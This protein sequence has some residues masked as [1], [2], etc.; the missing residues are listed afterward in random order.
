MGPSRGRT[1]GSS[2]AV[3]V[4]LLGC[5]TVGSQV[6]RAILERSSATDLAV[7]VGAP[8]ELCG[9]AVARRDAVRH[10]VDDSLFTFDAAALIEGTRPDVVIELIGGTQAVPLLH[11]A[12]E[13]GC[14]V[15]TANKSVLAMHLRALT[16]L[17]AGRGVDLLYEAAVAGAIP[18]VRVLRSSLAG[19][20]LTRIL[21]IVNGT[22]NFVLT[23]MSR[24]HRSY[25]DVL[26]QATAL[27]YAE[28]DASADVDGHDAA[29]KAAILATLA[30]G[31]EVTDADV[32]REGISKI[33]PADLDAARRMGYVVRLLAV[34]E[35]VDHE[36]LTVRV[37]PTMLPTGHPLASVEGATNAIFVEGA[38]HGP[39]MLEGRGA[40]G[41]E[42]ASAVLGDLVAVARNRRGG[43]TEQPPSFAQRAILRPAGDVASAFYLAIEVADRPGVLASVATVFGHHGVSIRSMEQV[44]LGDD[45]RLVFLTHRASTS[46]MSSTVSAL[47]A[48][49]AVTRVGALLEVLDDGGQE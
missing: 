23:T 10:G 9:I 25:T 26:E 21:G 39:L 19:Q 40:G 44:G 30:F 17:A 29:Q 15:V 33:T 31:M 5:G 13:A 32:P 1:T 46:Q 38:L 47:A 48:L 28:R 18:V 34:A 12:I 22:T 14:S 20:R 45:A 24:E 42:T 8:I 11:Q 37:H 6:A 7:A 43:M 36:A 2:D 4:A 41:A 16:D 27:G 35:R 49:D 3:R